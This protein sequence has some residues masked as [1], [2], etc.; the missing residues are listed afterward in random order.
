MSGGRVAGT[1]HEGARVRNHHGVA[2]SS[3][4]RR[5]TPARR[6]RARD[7]VAAARTR[8]ERSWAG[9][10]GRHLQELDFVNWITMFG[11]SLLWSA[12][13]LLIVLSSLADERIDDDLSRHIGL[14]GQGARI[15]HSLFRGTP[16][17]AIEPIVTGVLFSLAGMLGAV[18]AMQV[19][20]E[21]IFG[22]ER[23]GWRNLPR[24]LVWTLALLAILTVDA[25][26]NRPARHAA[27]A[28]GL[29]LVGLVV[30]TAFFWWTMHYLLA[31]RTP[32]GALVRPAIT[33]GVLWFVLALFSS[34]YFSPILISDSHMYGTIGVVF[35]LLTWFFLVGAVIVLGA[36]CGAA[37][38]A[39]A[40]DH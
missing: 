36:V 4:D 8:Y 27:G 39:H 32:W 37:W 25:A 15:V 7:Q 22:Q 19:I 26:L 11:A 6:D 14:N 21:R 5:S 12:V 16:A 31:G 10:I 34:V 17:H 18:G 30:T 33:T 38:Q 35:T 2:S 28:A 13:P 3:P 20:Y 23:R 29:D 40:E 1:L 24:W 9:E